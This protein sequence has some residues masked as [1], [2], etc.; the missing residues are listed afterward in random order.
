[1]K[2]LST[3]VLVA[4]LALFAAPARAQATDEEAPEV[5]PPSKAPGLAPPAEGPYVARNPA[6]RPT[7]I[8]LATQAIPSPELVVGDEG[9]RFGMRWQLTP[10]LYSFGI[11]RRLSPLR[12]FVVEPLVR[13]SGSVELFFSPEWVAYQGGAARLHTGARVYVPVL[14]RGEY[15]SFSVGAA[16]SLFDGRPGVSYEAGAYVLFGLLGL[17]TSVSPT[18]SHSPVATTFTLRVR[19]F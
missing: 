5:N 10:L 6:V 3:L 9:A 17:V 7:W 14:H 18:P 8:W 15:L 13:H 16:Y 1:M 12:S 11:H 19:Y 4:P 2:P